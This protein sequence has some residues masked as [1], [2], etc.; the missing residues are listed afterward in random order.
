MEDLPVGAYKL[1]G[2]HHPKKSSCSRSSPSVIQSTTSTD[3]VLDLQIPDNFPD[4]VDNIVLTFSG[5]Y[6]EHH[7]YKVTYLF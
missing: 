3:C 5:K 1:A 4:L 2:C 6:I 7:Y